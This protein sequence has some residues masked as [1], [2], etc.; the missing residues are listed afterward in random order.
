MG[1]QRW[2]FQ[3]LC[4]EMLKLI[5][6]WPWVLCEEFGPQKKSSNRWNSF[7]K[8]KMQSCVLLVKMGN[9]PQ[10]GV[11]IKNLWNHHLVV[12][13]FYP[14]FGRNHQISE[15]KRLAKRW[16]PSRAAVRS[17][18]CST[19]AVPCRVSP[20]RNSSMWHRGGPWQEVPVPFSIVEIWNKNI[21]R[22][23]MFD[24]F[25]CVFVLAFRLVY[26]LATVFV[27]GQRSSRMLDSILILLGWLFNPFTVV[28]G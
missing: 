20:R 11:K 26:S 15:A 22:V 13:C 12:F 24:E 21:G 14:Q 17:Q 28:L 6:F 3:Y 16:D 1:L 2:W 10:I 4:F 23:L 7:L 25:L 9:L 19:A 8:K 27:G 18:R 5:P